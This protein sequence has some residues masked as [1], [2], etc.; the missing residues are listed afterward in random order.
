MQKHAK[1]R[2]I[3]IVLD[4]RRV[5]ARLHE[6]LLEVAMRAGVDI[7]HLCHHPAL[8]ASGACRLCLV[9]VAR[10]GR[11]ALV[12]SCTYPAEHGIE[13]VTS[14]EKIHRHRRMILE[15]LLARA[16]GVPVIRELAAGY[17]VEE[18]RFPLGDG[19]RR[20]A[21]WKRQIGMRLR[22]RWNNSS[23]PESGGIPPQEFSSNTG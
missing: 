12:A 18:P 9:E 17:G 6:P 4:G 15:L 14:S 16:P 1:Q 8:E 11:R 10:R 13:V 2:E 7:L 19:G 5:E 20:E 23:P 21:F 3:S 22:S